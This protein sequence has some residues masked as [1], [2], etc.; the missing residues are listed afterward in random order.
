MNNQ[1]GGGNNIQQQIV[2]LMMQHQRPNQM[3]PQ[4][5]EFMNILSSNDAQRGEAIANNLCQ[6]MGI[7]RDEAVR[8]AQQFF[9]NM[10][11]G[12]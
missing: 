10:I 11:R 4:Q 5:K 1:N 6:S 7:S 2:N 9:Q 12:G 3:T 8:Q